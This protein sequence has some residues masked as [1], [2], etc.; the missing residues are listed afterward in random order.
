VSTT[1]QYQ[2]APTRRTADLEERAQR[3]LSNRA[4]ESEGEDHGE[5][6]ETREERDGEIREGDHTRFPRQTLL[7]RQIAREG[8]HGAHPER[9]REERLARRRGECLA[10]EQLGELRCEIERVPGPA[11]AEGRSPDREPE[12]DQAQRRDHDDARPLDSLL[13]TSH[14]DR[15]RDGY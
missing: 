14:H 5:G 15:D 4:L 3:T 6:D 1:R 13:D 11:P 12:H 10:A 8:E 9:E 7:A 2:S